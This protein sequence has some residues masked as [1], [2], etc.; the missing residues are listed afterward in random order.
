M[1]NSQSSICFLHLL[2]SKLALR[3]PIPTPLLMLFSQLRIPSPLFLLVSFK[4]QMPLLRGYLFDMAPHLHSPEI[5]FFSLA[6]VIH[7]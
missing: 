4:G 6:P 7:F 2:F 5:S 3:V 1:E